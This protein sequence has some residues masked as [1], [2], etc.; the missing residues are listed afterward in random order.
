M[1]WL[2]RAIKQTPRIN[3]APFDQMMDKLDGHY[4]AP[5]ATAK[6]D[7]SNPMTMTIQPAFGDSSPPGHRSLQTPPEADIGQRIKSPSSYYGGGAASEEDAADE[8]GGLPSYQASPYGGQTLNN[9][10]LINHLINSG[11]DTVQR[12][13]IQHNLDRIL[14]MPAI[15][16]PTYRRQAVD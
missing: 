8:A 12:R 16:R 7:P 2:K 9:D 1:I 5:P 15:D 11:N 10:V 3:E 4:P 6:P 14:S 13:A